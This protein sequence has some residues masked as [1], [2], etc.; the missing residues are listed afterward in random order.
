MEKRRHLLEGV[1]G[2]VQAACCLLPADLQS[3]ADVFED[4]LDGFTASVAA[5]DDVAL[6]VEDD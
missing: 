1:E 4:E 2:Y 5:V 6:F 3:P